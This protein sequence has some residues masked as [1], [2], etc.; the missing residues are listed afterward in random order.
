MFIDTFILLNKTMPENETVVNS[1]FFFFA[2]KSGIWCLKNTGP[3]F[4]GLLK[5]QSL[6]A[7]CLNS[8]AEFCRSVCFDW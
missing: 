4:E 8:D 5:K 2:S 1:S 6:S 7:V 3:S